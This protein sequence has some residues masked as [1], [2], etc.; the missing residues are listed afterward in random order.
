M[1]R[2]SFTSSSKVRFSTKKLKKGAALS[3]TEVREYSDKQHVQNN[4]R[5]ACAY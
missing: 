2:S 5:L 1:V 4:K 3:G